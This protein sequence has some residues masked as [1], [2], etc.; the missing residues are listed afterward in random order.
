MGVN[1]NKNDI[2]LNFDTAEYYSLQEAC[3]YLNRKHKIDNLT[4]KKLLKQISS[5]NI[6]TFIH[7]RMDNL[8]KKPLRVKIQSYDSNVF[9]DDIYSLSEEEVK[10]TLNIISK[11]E[12]L[13]SNN[14][15][16]DLYMGF[17]LFRVDEYSLFNMS[18]FNNLQESTILLL[19]E[20]FVY[21]TSHNDDPSKPKQLDKWTITVDDK[22]YRFF[23]IGALNFVI[24]S[25][26][27]DDLNE[28]SEIAPYLCSFD[29]RD[30]F[31]FVNFSININDLIVLHKDLLKLEEDIITNKIIEIKTQFEPRRGVSP[32]KVLAQSLAKH[33]ADNEWKRDSEE[34]IKMSEMASIVWSQL[35]SLGFSDTLPEEKRV[36]EWIKEIAPNYASEAG[37]PREK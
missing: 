22:E 13:V 30:T 32:K 16:D 25:T 9:P 6:N 1:M 10:P 7:F 17:I 36:R 19:I 31:S 29:K 37:R 34:R 18:M 15:I 20:G 14:L 2:A 28:F 11:L 8:S 3:D 4:P 24:D 5:R 12:E 21:N 23:E 27:D 33:I 35:W 26:N